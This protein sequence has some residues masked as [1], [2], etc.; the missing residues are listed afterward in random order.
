MARIVLDD[1]YIKSL[2]ITTNRIEVS[3]DKDKF[4]AKYS[5]VSYY[6]TDPE[7]KNL[8]YEQFGDVPFI[9]VSGIRDRWGAQ[10]FPSV[11][12]FILTTKGKED[13]VLNSLRA[14]ND[15]KAWNNTL[16][17]Y[18][19]K[20]RQ[21]IIAS[22]AINSLGK[23]KNSNM[24][25]NDG[26]LLVCDDKNF[27]ARKS[28]KE[29]VCLKIEVNEYMNLTA[30]TTSFSNPFNEKELLKH[31]TC[32]FQIAKDFDGDY[33]SGQAVKPIIIK[34]VK[35]G[36]YDLKKLFIQ[37]K[38]FNDN[39][40]LVP[41]WPFNVEDYSHGKL[42]V[43]WQVIESV[44]DAFKGIIEV[45]FRD[46]QVIHY[47]ECKT[48]DGI[49]ALIQEY[50]AERSISFEDPFQTSGSKSVIKNFKNEALEIMSGH[51]VFPKKPTPDDIIIKL[52]EPKE[53]E[54]EATLYS[55]SMVRML[56]NGNALQHITYY[57]D[58]KLD[59]LD[60]FRV[61]RILIELI[62][63]DSLA[64]RVMP[65]PLADML[66]GWNAIR[67][68]INQGNVHGAS[69]EIDD[70]GTIEIKQYGLSL[71][72]QG[73][74]FENFI[75]Q[76]LKYSEY[77]KIRGA[78]DYMAL[79]KN[80]NVYFIV[81]TDEIPILDV[82]LIDEAYS[83]VTNEGETVAMFKRK[84]VA[85]DYLR[86]YIGFHLWKSEGIDGEPYSSY[87]YI[88]GTN[89]ESMKI[90][91]KTKMDK[92][93]RARRIFI[94]HKENPEL[95]EQHIFEI[96]G[97]LKFGFGRWNE[98]MTYP[99]PF[100]FLQEYLDDAAETAFSIHWKDITYKKDL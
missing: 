34:S 18:E 26:S 66:I 51:I 89:S 45:N 92:M 42:Y 96:C 2:P 76:N 41:Y 71:D 1:N 16:E 28:R 27:G 31:R 79:V 52:C 59:L 24:M 54:S 43:I 49:L 8:A 14:Y 84:K 57:G 69:M 73:E 5:I 97:M 44:N 64:K 22:L 87:S 3:W 75:S 60:T 37:K 23:K 83:Q 4:F 30:R 13:E 77:D 15:V 36:E 55:Q 7:H 67:Y 80:G 20:V 98:L 70:H 17:K 90:T 85:H 63:K 81:D 68:K 25:Y 39:K 40:N 48:K 33:W 74:D 47:D 82:N 35:N 91:P 21:R 86:G 65:K 38:N 88:S 46:S 9:S 62:V 50:L 10:H 94:L 93:P 58:E 78:R 11:Q 53:E 6:S 95:I 99:F 29:L 100:K 32:A 72:N 56:N 12:F 19:D 61:R